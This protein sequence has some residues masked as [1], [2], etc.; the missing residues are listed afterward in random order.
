MIPILIVNIITLLLIVLNVVYFKSQKYLFLFIP[1]MLFLPAYYGIEISKIF[2]IIEIRRIMFCV[3]Y[4]Y[5]FVNRKKYISNTDLSIK[6]I[7]KEYSFLILSFTLRIVSC[8]YYL[9]EHLQAYKTILEIVFEEILLL[10]C[11]HIMSL[12]REDLL[13]LIN[14]IVWSST[15]IFAVGIFESFTFIRP[16]DF[17]YTVSRSVLNEHYVRLGLLRATTTFG[18]PVV[19]GGVCLIVFPA[20][21]YMMLKTNQ[22][23]YYMA[24][25]INVMAI[26]HSGA[27]SAQLFFCFLMVIFPLFIWN[28]D[29]VKK[30][31]KSLFI[32]ILIV[33]IFVL[34]LCKLSPK[35]EYFYEGSAKAVLNE[36]GFDFELDANVPEGVEGYGD[37]DSTGSY[38]RVAEFSG[39]KYALEK[40]FWFGLGDGC[41][42]RNEIRYLWFGKWKPHKAIDIGIVEVF[43]T[44]GVIG[45]LAFLCLFIFI[46][47]TIIKM[48]NGLEKRICFLTVIAYLLSTLGTSNIF[49]FLFAFVAIIMSYQKVQNNMID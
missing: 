20:I 26:I 45:F 47:Y 19:F 36:V 15:V 44:E 31:F 5:V 46:M 28:K 2:P 39:I 24:F 35:Y 3:F 7:S 27:R 12:S 18:M 9:A 13:K 21:I 41:D 8:S 48:K 10:V 6:T 33:G 11:I 32:S 4:F 14:I 37:N 22:K 29:E 38:S 17:L 23:K 40:N 49:S 16:F 30:Y 25:I 1:C 43:M 42:Q 34:L